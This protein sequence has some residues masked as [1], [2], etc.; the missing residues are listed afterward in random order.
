MIVALLFA[1]LPH[2]R[3]R[4]TVASTTQKRPPR[5][6]NARGPGTRPQGGPMHTEGT[7]AHVVR[8]IA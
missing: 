8:V 1:A 7:D 3:R 4:A 6:A 2:T 5:R